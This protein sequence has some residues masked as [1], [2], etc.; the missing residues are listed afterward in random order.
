[1]RLAPPSGPDVRF[2]PR[3]RPVSLWRSC[4]L[5]HN[6]P[7][8]ARMTRVAVTTAFFDFCP[9]LKAEL[10]TALSRCQVPHGPPSSERGRADRIPQ[11]LRHSRCRH[12]LFYRARMRGAARSEGDLAV[13]GRRRSH[14]SRRPQQHGIRMWWAPGV[15]RVSVAELAVCYMILALRRVHEFSSILRRGQW[16]G[17]VGFGADFA[18]QD[19]G[20]PRLRSHRQRAGQALQPF[21]VSVSRAT[22]STSSIST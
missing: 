21:G 11:K 9:E 16:K 17:P 22:A 20:H 10:A 14:R 1:M 18:W 7:D 12:R 15:N 5:V 13:L 19:G 8:I 4:L 3:G 2:S 6:L